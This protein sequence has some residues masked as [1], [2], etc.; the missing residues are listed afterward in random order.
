MRDE[1]SSLGWAI[2]RCV[3]Y[4][5]AAVAIS[6]ATMPMWRQFLNPVNPHTYSS[7]D[8]ISVLVPNGQFADVDVGLQPF[9][10]AVQKQSPELGGAAVTLTFHGTSGAKPDKAIIY[11]FFTGY[12]RRFAADCSRQLMGASVIPWDKL[13]G[14]ILERATIGAESRTIFARVQVNPRETYSSTCLVP[15][16]TVWF[17]ARQ[18]EYFSFPRLTIVTWDKHRATERERRTFA[19]VEPGYDLTKF[20][21]AHTCL[22]TVYQ[23][24]PDERLDVVET[25][26]SEQPSTEPGKHLWITCTSTDN[27]GGGSGDYIEWNATTAAA[28]VGFVVVDNHAE[29]NNERDLFFA[30]IALG[31]A[32][33]FLVEGFTAS[34]AALESITSSAVGWIRQRRQREP[35]ESEDAD[36]DAYMNLW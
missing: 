10:Q 17:Q 1:N 8:A 4:L 15:D 32:G 16:R 22:A 33:A 31:L 13:P 30:G 29:S 9:S 20:L 26:S 35:I 6:I 24:E 18:K 3:I 34:L 27:G 2:G 19:S 28:A 7:R 21:S 25:G 23:S 11:L 36:N 5:G 12:A 14:E